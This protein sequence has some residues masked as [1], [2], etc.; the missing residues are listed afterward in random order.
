MN[1]GRAAARNAGIENSEG[2]FLVFNDGDRVPARNLIDVYCEKSNSD[3]IC[4]G[5][6]YD[7]F[8][9]DLNRIDNME[10]DFIERFSRLPRYY[11]DVVSKCDSENF[12]SFKYPWMSFMVGNSCV[13]REVLNSSG[14]FDERFKEWGGEHFE[15]GYRMYRSGYKFLICDSARNYHIPHKREKG[16]YKKYITE[17]FQLINEIHKEIDISDCMKYLGIDI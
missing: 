5:Y 9:M 4:V 3:V 15:L 1:A 7:Y 16:F 11:K 2:S 12:N 13:S 17:S 10:W 14:F 6:S 8:G